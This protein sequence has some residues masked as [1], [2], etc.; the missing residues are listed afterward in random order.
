MHVEEQALHITIADDGKGFG[1]LSH[2]QTGNGLPG[3]KRRM[4]QMAGTL[5]IQSKKKTIVKFEIPLNEKHV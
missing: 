4:Q 5:E 3:M 1:L 2:E